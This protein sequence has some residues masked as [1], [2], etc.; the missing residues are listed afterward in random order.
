MRNRRPSANAVEE[1]RQIQRC[2]EASDVGLFPGSFPNYQ[3]CN[4]LFKTFNNQNN[5]HGNHDQTHRTNNSRKF[6]MPCR[7]A[8]SSTSC[9]SRAFVSVVM[10]SS[11]SRLASTLWPPEGAVSS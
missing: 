7:Y 6:N 9:S 4:G 11:D 10:I 8:A 1:E 2:L 3:N 5:K